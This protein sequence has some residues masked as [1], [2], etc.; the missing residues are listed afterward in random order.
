MW[1][2]GFK[3]GVSE[4]ALMGTGRPA[5]VPFM[6]IIGT[7]DA[8]FAFDRHFVAGADFEEAAELACDE[9]EAAV[10]RF[11]DA[12]VTLLNRI[13]YLNAFH[14]ELKRRVAAHHSSGES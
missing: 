14:T 5:D 2:D 3:N 1:A 6:E 11:A 12:G 8:A 9:A 7:D 4:S 10:L 13:A